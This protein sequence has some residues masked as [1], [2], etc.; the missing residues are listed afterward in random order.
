MSP[1]AD[2]PPMVIGLEGRNPSCA[3]FELDRQMIDDV[4]RGSSLH[5]QVPFPS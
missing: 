1:L 4:E 3:P 5:A 2:T